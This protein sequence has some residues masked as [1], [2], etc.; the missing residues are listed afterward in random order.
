EPDP[1]RT[2]V[3]KAREIETRSK[4]RHSTGSASISAERRGRRYRE[5]GNDRTPT[6]RKQRGTPQRCSGRCAGRQAPERQRTTRGGEGGDGRAPEREGSP[7]PQPA[8]APLEAWQIAH[9]PARPR[10]NAPGRP[11]HGPDEPGP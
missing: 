6:S 1:V 3:G 11:A 4:E 2:G 7:F 5:Q 10:R 9:A 8:R